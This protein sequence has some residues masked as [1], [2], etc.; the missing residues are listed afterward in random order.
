MKLIARFFLVIVLFQ[1]NLH[2][3]SFFFS[4]SWNEEYS[5]LLKVKTYHVFPS[6][7]PDH[8]VNKLV[9]FKP[10]VEYRF[11]KNGKI[12]TNLYDSAFA[13]KS[14]EVDSNYVM[15]PNRQ[16]ITRYY[17]GDQCM[18]KLRKY[19][20]T[21]AIPLY[22]GAMAGSI[23]RELDSIMYLAKYVGITDYT[24]S[25]KLLDYLRTYKATQ[26]VFTDILVYEPIWPNRPSQYVKFTFFVFDV[27]SKKMFFY[28]NLYEQN[29]RSL[30]NKDQDIGFNLAD[31]LGLKKIVRKYKS[32]LKPYIK[33]KN[34]EN[35]H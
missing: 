33:Y 4:N 8:K 25:D 26:F 14:A 13:S 5:A 34:H 30:I 17:F 10:F 7:I 35:T 22:G 27:L 12:S 2:A 29:G 15:F 11:Y 28:D 32:C 1:C 23:K 3:Q 21:T 18:R 20:D 24:M 9:I 19:T 6:K 31:M 16:K